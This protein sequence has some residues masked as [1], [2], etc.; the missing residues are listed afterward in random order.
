MSV[1]VPVAALVV[2]GIVLAVLGLLAPA[3]ELTYVGIAAI[4]VAGILAVIGQRRT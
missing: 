1:N 2:L 3:I 4:V